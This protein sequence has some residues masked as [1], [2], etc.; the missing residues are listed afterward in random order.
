MQIPATRR[1]HDRGRLGGKILSPADL[2][3]EPFCAQE[4]Y[5]DQ[6]GLK[7]LEDHEF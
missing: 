2:C 5:N 3:C 4:D 6:V 7:R 1:Q